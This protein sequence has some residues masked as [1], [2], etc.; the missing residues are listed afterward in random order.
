MKDFSKIKKHVLDKLKKELPMDLYYHGMHHTL[1][2]VDSIN[3]ICEHEK[4]TSN[5]L[6]LLNVG[7]LYHDIGFVHVYKNHEEEGCKIA[8]EEL[9]KFGLSDDEVNIICG[10]IM[11][12]KIPQSP[13]THLE[14]IIADADLEYLG[15]AD[16]W[17]VGRTLFDELKIYMDVSNESQWNIIQMN[18]LKKHQYFTDFCKMYREPKKKEYLEQI[19]KIVENPD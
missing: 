19:I 17:D 3:I 11:A 8:K 16:Y 7:G 1:S 2:V 14:Q 6:F 9:P 15:T 12:T 4:I 10:L 13:K 18:F 5:E